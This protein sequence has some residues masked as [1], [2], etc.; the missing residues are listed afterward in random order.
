MLSGVRSGKIYAVLEK[1]SIKILYTEKSERRKAE[2]YSIREKMSRDDHEDA[3]Y[4]K[5]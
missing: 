1:V 4:W 5:K 2:R 3:P